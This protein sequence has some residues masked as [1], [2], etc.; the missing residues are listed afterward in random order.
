M[1]SPI[2]RKVLWQPH[3]DVDGALGVR[4]GDVAIGA[5]ACA[6]WRTAAI[7]AFAADV[8]ATRREASD[9]PN[10]DALFAFIRFLL[11][12]ADADHL[13]ASR[14]EGAAAVA[15]AVSTTTTSVAVASCVATPG[16]WALSQEVEYG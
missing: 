8:V 11:E 3:R 5:Q 15:A 10:A 9:F 16:G 12:I 4:S 1:R 7:V 14:R 6:D 2:Q 13:A